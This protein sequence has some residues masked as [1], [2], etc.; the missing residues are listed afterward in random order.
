ML[1]TN[2]IYMR[3]KKDDE[4]RKREIKTVDLIEIKRQRQRRRRRVVSA[5]CA[6]KRLLT[7][8]M[9]KKLPSSHPSSSLSSL[10][11]LPGMILLILTSII[12]V[13]YFSPSSS[14]QRLHIPFQVW[15]F[16]SSS[17]FMRVGLR[18]SKYINIKDLP[19]SRISNRTF[20]RLKMHEINHLKS[21]HQSHNNHHF[22]PGHNYPN[23]NGLSNHKSNGSI[24]GV[25]DGTTRT[26]TSDNYQ[27]TH[28][29]HPIR[30]RVSS[31]PI[32]SSSALHF[33][34]RPSTNVNTRGKVRQSRIGGV[35]SESQ[36]SNDDNHSEVS[37]T[38]TTS[39][40]SIQS[41]IQKKNMADDSDHHSINRQQQ[42]Q[43]SNNLNHKNDKSS[44]STPSWLQRATNNILDLSRIP[45]GQLTSDDIE[46]ISGLMANWAKN[47]KNK[48]SSISSS[49]QRQHQPESS[50]IQV[51]TLLKRVVD[52]H[53][54]GND[55]VKVTTRMYTMAIDAW[56]KTGGKKAAER[57]HMIHANMVQMYK[58]TGD[59]NIKPSTIS[60]NA[61]LNA[62]SKSGCEEACYKAESILEEMLDGYYN[63]CKG[64]KSLLPSKSTNG[65]SILENMEEVGQNGCSD[66]VVKPDVVS[67]TSVIGTLNQYLIQKDVFVM[68]C[69]L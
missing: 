25:A 17:T 30:K 66:D 56:A 63:S 34:L 69:L 41:T 51:E 43:Q 48:N 58:Y 7:K 21:H 67:F 52:D 20:E 50:A 49:Q 59:D 45:L 60:Y 36:Y 15:A 57:A 55:S 61:V 16:S 27:Q 8:T 44:D 37:T 10:L 38:R 39:S 5:S 64:S 35:A 13:H 6:G 46:S 33:Q 2:E 29:Q 62:W 31:G 24:I 9:R 68:T 53:N 65:E 11:F 23:N 19:M 14:I 28:H 22:H 40:N 4:E 54:Y 12:D 1:T 42:Q 26:T 47:N 3:M 18:A 32:F